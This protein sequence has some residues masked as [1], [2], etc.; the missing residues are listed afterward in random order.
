MSSI[1]VPFGHGFNF[2]LTHAESIYFCNI[3]RAISLIRMYL[4]KQP[5]T[6]NV[7]EKNLL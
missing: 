1:E 4:G 5:I 2:L 7:A 6:I 3:L